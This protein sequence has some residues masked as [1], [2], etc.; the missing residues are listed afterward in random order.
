MCFLMTLVKATLIKFFYSSL[1]VLLELLTY[2]VTTLYK[3][4]CKAKDLLDQR[5]IQ[6]CTES[7]TNYS[8][9]NNPS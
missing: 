1:H 7:T 4:F 8:L 9:I 3:Y 2:L 5:F 6:L